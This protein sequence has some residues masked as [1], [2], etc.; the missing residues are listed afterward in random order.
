MK[1]M[2]GKYAEQD[3]DDRNLRMALLGSKGNKQD[4]KDVLEQAARS[5][6]RT[7]GKPVGESDGEDEAASV[8]D[9]DDSASV[10]DSSHPLSI[11]DQLRALS[12][13]EVGTSS[14]AAAAADPIEE[15]IDP[16]EAT[17]DIAIDQLGVLDTMT[18]APLPG[19]NLAFAIPVCAPYSTLSSYKYRVKLVPGAMKK[20]KACKM[21]LTVSVNAADDRK[22]K[23]VH[24]SDPA[25][26]ERLELEVI[27][28]NREKELMKA[29]P[30]Q[31]LISQMLGKVKVTAPNM[32]SIRQ[33]SKA[34][35]K[36]KAKK[37][38]KAIA[39]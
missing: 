28:T 38:A 33:K 18:P 10:P 5:V 36:S 1:K 35:A 25:E 13:R 22:P 17:A 8:L 15:D 14:D 2:K 23:V 19:D 12:T 7:S 20:G 34:A 26:A 31:E 32:E 21:A 27:L 3:D 9:A 29:V 39:E 4:A 6:Q 16:D 24:S 11:V 37:K 30:E